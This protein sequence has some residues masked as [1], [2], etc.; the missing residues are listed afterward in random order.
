MGGD[1]MTQYANYDGREIIGFRGYENESVT[2][3]DQYGKEVG[4]STKRELLR[5]AIRYH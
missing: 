2:P 1:G 3:R 5:S 4:A